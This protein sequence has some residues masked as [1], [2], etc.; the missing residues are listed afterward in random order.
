MFAGLS[1]ES[2]RHLQPLPEAGSYVH[3]SSRSQYPS[4]G[5]LW[6]PLKIFRLTAPPPPQL[7][8]WLFLAALSALRGPLPGAPSRVH[9]RKQRHLGAYLVRLRRLPRGPG[10]GG[11]SAA[12]SSGLASSLGLTSPEPRASPGAVAAPAAFLSGCGWPWA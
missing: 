9:S 10:K 3:A 1:H 6:P 7:P 8:A 11:A 2:A 12:S 4:P 5:P